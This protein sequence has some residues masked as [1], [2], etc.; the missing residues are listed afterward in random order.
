MIYFHI[1]TCVTALLVCYKYGDWKHWNK[2]Y[3]TILF[4]IAG[5]LLYS[6]V[7]HNNL[8]WMY[9][10]DIL[11]HT[12]INMLMM[13]TVYPATVMLFIPNYPKGIFNKVVYTLSWIFLFSLA[14]YIA[15]LLGCFSYED[16][17][18]VGWSIIFNLVMFPLLYLHDKKPLLAW[19]L[20]I[21]ELII[22]L[23]IFD[24]NI[25]NLT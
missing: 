15:V 16:G 10:T 2:Y 1:A 23:I 20:A 19:F 5:D 21:V 18:S 7:F 11:N 9:V 13:V 12:L 3:S 24:V 4:F 17:W 14:E 6:Q 22:Y 25:L 8:L